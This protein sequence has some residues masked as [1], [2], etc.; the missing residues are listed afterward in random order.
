MLT[1]LQAAMQTSNDV[2]ERDRIYQALVNFHGETLLLM[3]WSIL[4]KAH[5]EVVGL[6]RPAI[7]PLPFLDPRCW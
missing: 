5:S 1:E 4:G 3:H 2:A 7:F 6:V